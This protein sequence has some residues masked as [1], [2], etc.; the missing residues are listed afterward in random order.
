MDAKIKAF[1][2]YS[3]CVASTIR[4]FARMSARSPRRS[5]R[6]CFI[7]RTLSGPNWS[8]LAFWA[9]RALPAEVFGPVECCQGWLRRAA[10]CSRRLPSSVRPFR[11]ARLRLPAAIPVVIVRAGRSP[12]W[13][14]CR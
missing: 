8:S 3:E 7:T 14:T 6:S 9:A 2:C 5:A 1:R 13:I 11:N 12:L 4:R 10:S